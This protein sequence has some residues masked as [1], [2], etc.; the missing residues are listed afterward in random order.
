MKPRSFCGKL[1]RLSFCG[2]LP[3][4]DRDTMPADPVEQ[5]GNGLVAQVREVRAIERRVTWQGLGQIEAERDLALEPRLDSVSI[6][7]NDLR[8]N[9]IGES[10]DVLVEDFGNQRSVFGRGNPGPLRSALKEHHA[11]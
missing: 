7:G 1:I 8:R 10:G 5:L 11:H 4:K 6:S 2:A 3:E 9:I